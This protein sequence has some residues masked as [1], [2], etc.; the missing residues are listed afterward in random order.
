VFW[1]GAVFHIDWSNLQQLIP[2]QMF[3]YIANVGRA[4]SDGFETELVVDPVRGLSLGGGLT[5]NNARLVGSQPVQLNP[6]LQLNAG[7]KL[8]NVPDWTVNGSATYTQ[9][10]RG[11]YVA[12]VRLDG[13][14]QSGRADLVA[15]Q[16]PAYFKIGSSTLVGLHVGLDSHRSWRLGLDASNLLNAYA[17]LSARALDSNYA[18][19]VVA[20][21]PRTVTLSLNVAY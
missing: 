8:A 21:R 1:T 18:K 4:R 2:T 6:A 20:A 16:N 3:N 5:Y 9:D 14:Y 10:L 7:D 11:G 12:S 17:P 15:T 19:T 13:S